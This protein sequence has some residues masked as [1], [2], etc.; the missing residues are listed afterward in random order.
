M[1]EID[2]VAEALEN[3]DNNIYRVYFIKPKFRILFE[4]Q[5]LEIIEN[6]KI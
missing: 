3:R 1:D 2:A 6:T 5:V 4:K